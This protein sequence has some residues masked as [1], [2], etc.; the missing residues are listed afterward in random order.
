M[1]L[2]N[3]NG[4]AR[5]TDFSYEPHSSEPPGNARFCNVILL[6]KCK[7]FFK[8]MATQ[9]FSLFFVAAHFIIQLISRMIICGG[10]D[11]KK[12]R[13]WLRGRI[14]AAGFPPSQNTM[15]GKAD[16][17]TNPILL[18]WLDQDRGAIVKRGG[19]GRGRESNTGNLK[20]KLSNQF[21]G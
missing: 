8:N 4:K 13:M 17:C 5:H 11:E 9:F 12:R 20:K 15:T 19:G 6:S 1:C 21:E 2:Y 16:I 10:S 18:Q 14:V 3:E 7:A